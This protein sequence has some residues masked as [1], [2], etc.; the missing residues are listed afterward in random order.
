[1]Y[2]ER[3]YTAMADK[4]VCL[5]PNTEKILWEEHLARSGNTDRKGEVLDALLSP[6]ALVNGKV[7]VGTDDGHLICLSAETGERL[8]SVAVGEPIV[9]QPAVAGGRAYVATNNGT[10]IAIET[11]DPADDGWLMW[12]A[13]AAHDGNAAPATDRSSEQ[14]KR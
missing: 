13:N 5:D 11:N 8:W 3:L 9:F 2:K 6:P 1:M 10:L 14:R 7:F 4:I 12:G